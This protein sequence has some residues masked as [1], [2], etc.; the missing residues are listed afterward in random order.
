MV[1]IHFV[2]TVPSNSFA[3]L[4]QYAYDIALK[5]LRMFYNATGFEVLNGYQDSNATANL[6]VIGE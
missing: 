2:S 3:G 1:S 4:Y 5:S 6:L